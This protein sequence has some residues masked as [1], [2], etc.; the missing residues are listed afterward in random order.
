MAELGFEVDDKIDII[1]NNASLLKRNCF[2]DEEWKS[3]YE[4][5]LSEKIEDIYLSCKLKKKGYNIYL[6]PNTNNNYII[7]NDLYNN[8]IDDQYDDQLNNFKLNYINNNYIQ[9]INKNDTKYYLPD[10]DYVVTYVDNNDVNWLKSY[11]NC[12]LKNHKQIFLKSARFRT[13]NTLKY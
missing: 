9:N 1:G 13:P 7:N 11:I 6:K 8:D 12:S 5:S 3:L 10:V 2:T 4:N